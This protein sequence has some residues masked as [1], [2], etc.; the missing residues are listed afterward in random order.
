[1]DLELSD[2]LAETKK[3]IRLKRLVTCKACRG[4]GAKDG[5]AMETCSTCHGTGQIRRYQSTFLGRI[6]NVVGCS[7]CGGEGRII[8]K[9][10]AEC[11][12]KGR[13]EAHETL[14]V[15]IPPGVATGNYLRIDG[16]GNDGLRGGPPGD[17]HVYVNVKDHPVFE[18]DGENIFCDIPISFPLAALGGKVDVPTLDGP[19]HLKIPAGTQS[20]K[21]FTLRGK[22][23][24]KVRGIGRGN[25][26]VRVTVWVPTK[27]SKDERDL[28]EKLSKF[29]DKEELKPGKSFL[30]KLKGLLGD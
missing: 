6:V 20:Q 22:G 1:V 16:K 18:R 12:G 7:R 14:E 19:H 26:Y 8:E 24:P 29:D 28:L 13:I 5:T 9:A 21:I 15:K 11:K 10:C 4:T 25:E 2:V 30:E 27:V 3:K 23:L 17:L